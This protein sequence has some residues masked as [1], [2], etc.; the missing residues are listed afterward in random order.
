MAG[1]AHPLRAVVEALREII[2]RAHGDLAEGLKWNAPSYSVE[3]KHRVTLNLHA[4]DRVR[5][6]FH[7]DARP[8]GKLGGRVLRDESGLLDWASEDR[9]IAAFSGVDELRAR[10]AQLTDLVRRWVEATRGV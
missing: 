4:R 7:C 10:E 9:A 5:V 2:P 8:K 3:G 1:L 6:I